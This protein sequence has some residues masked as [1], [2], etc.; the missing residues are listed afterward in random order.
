MCEVVQIKE[1][2]IKT[3]MPRANIRYYEK[4]GLL[5]RTARNMYNYREYTKED[6]EQLQRIKILRLLEV[7]MEEI[8]LYKDDKEKLNLIIIERMKIIQ[9]MVNDIINEF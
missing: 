3:G 2:E 1:V 9:K 5:N 6:V 7:P 4:A 8:R